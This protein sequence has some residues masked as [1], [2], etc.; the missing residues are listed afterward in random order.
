M[1]YAN[2]N[3]MYFKHDTCIMQYKLYGCVA[4]LQI[5]IYI[6]SQ[7]NIQEFKKKDCMIFFK[8]VI[9]V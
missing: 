6:V 9:E 3:S 7:K 5:K 1:K 2:L 4:F 8:P